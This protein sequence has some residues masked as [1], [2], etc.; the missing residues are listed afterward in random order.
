[1]VGMEVEKR[2][3]SGNKYTVEMLSKL[4]QNDL[5]SLRNLIGV[6]L[7]A[8]KVQKFHSHNKGVEGCWQALGEYQ[9]AVANEDYVPALCGPNGKAPAVN[10]PVVVP[11]CDLP[12]Y[13]KRPT[14]SMFRRVK[15]ISH[16][17]KSQRPG[18][19]DRYHDG[20]RI[21]DAMEANGVHAGK[22]GWYVAQG[23]MELVTP[24][25]DV[26]EA[27]MRQWYSNAGREYPVDSVVTNKA[28]REAK[29][30]EREAAKAAKAEA[31]EIAK[32][33]KAEATALKAT[34]RAEKKAA[35]DA[36]KAEQI[37]KA[38]AKLTAKPKKIAAA[39]E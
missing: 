25:P 28:E 3:F 13:V 1:M 2:E 5:T 33:A 20:M 29:K 34:E 38:K 27:E 8:S 22:I 31:R 16:P 14:P 9:K 18:V 15:K 26:I 32:A 21:I 12:E 7:G 36:K 19:W 17:D 4:A 24:E 37:E 10:K 23:L 11:T 39:A 6:N 35:S 30:A